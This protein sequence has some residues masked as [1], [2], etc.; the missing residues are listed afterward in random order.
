MREGKPEHGWICAGAY[1][2]YLRCDIVYHYLLK[3]QCP[4][5]G[6]RTILQVKETT[7]E[8]TLAFDRKSG[9]HY[10][11]VLIRLVQILDS[12]NSNSGFDPVGA[13]PFTIFSSIP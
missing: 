5:R 13:C 12:A 1:I 10:Y 2:Y 3:T 4:M 7:S 11:M 6:G 8:V 9:G